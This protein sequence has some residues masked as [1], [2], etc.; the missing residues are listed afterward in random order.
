M[1]G[2]FQGIN[3]MSSALRAFQRALD[4]TGHNISNVNTSGYSRQSVQFNQ[5]D[6]SRFLG[7]NNYYVGNGVSAASVSRIQD[8]FLFMRQIEASSDGGRLSS[9]SEGLNGVQSVMNEPGGASIGDALDKFYNAWSAL[10]S[11]PGDA[12]LKQQVQQAG[13][14]LGSRVRSMYSNLQSQSAQVGSQIKGSIE[15]AQGLI[16]TIADMNAQIRSQQVPGAIPNDVLDA[17]DQAIQALSQIMP[18][19]VQAQQDGTVMLFSGQMTLV[20][21]TGS[22]TIP[23]TYDAISGSLTDGTVTYPVRS[24]SLAGLFQTSQS[25]RAYQQKLDTLANSMRTQFNSVHATGTN[26]LGATGQNFFNDSVPQTGAIDFDIDA[27]I[28]SDARNIATGVTG[29][30]GDGGLALSMSALR[31]VQISGLGGKTMGSYFSDL[32]TGVGQD[33]A[34]AESYAITSDAIMTQIGQQI[35]S[36]SGVSIDDEMANMLRY[37]RS[38]QAAAKAL[39]VFDETTEDLLNMIR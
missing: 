16:D 4:V 17:R 9:L 11:N 26:E 21:S 13:A 24:G 36:V 5:A 1:P 14:T 6:P 15:R 8:Q 19:T 25:I 37:Q 22:A 23:T 32:V 35:Q 38:Y 28:K 18:V 39:S 20:D 29:N 12:V 31:D 3:T 10:G 30:P 7:I 34:T 33:A 27:A 2:P